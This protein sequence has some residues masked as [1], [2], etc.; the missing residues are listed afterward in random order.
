[1]TSLVTYIGNLRT[2]AEHMQSGTLIQTDAPVDNQGT[3]SCFS[4][5]DLVATALG[6]CIATIM[7]I[8][9]RDKG[10]SME[11]TRFE[12]TKKMLASPRRIGEIIVDVHFP[13]NGVLSEA[14][15]KILEAA[16]MTCPVLASL[17][18]DT[19]KTISF[20]PGSTQDA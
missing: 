11:G 6:T 18:P 12:I 20:Y 10:I 3:G 5:T 9:A 8:K 1:M 13:P 14:D 17:H 19:Q 15:R 16:A 2:Q 4:P 7:G